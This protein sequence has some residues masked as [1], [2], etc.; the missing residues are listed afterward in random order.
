MIKKLLWVVITLLL[1]GGIVSGEQ[2]I[3]N[4][5]VVY[6]EW[7]SNSW[8][9]GKISSSCPEGYLVL[10]DDGAE[11]CC[12][13]WEIVLDESPEKDEAQVNTAVLAEWSNG[14]FYPGIIAAI[15]EDEYKIQYDDGDISVVKLSQLRL[16]TLPPED[17][18]S[19]VQQNNQTSNSSNTSSQVINTGLKIWRG[20]SIWA[21]ISADGDIWIDG[22]H[23]GEIEPDGD[24]WRG[25]SYVGEIES[26]GDIWIQS[27]KDAEIET[28]GDIWLNS[29]QIAQIEPNGKIWFKS[30]S[31]GEVTPFDGNYEDMKIIAAV[32]I[33]FAPEFGYTD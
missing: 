16:R 28:D 11:K 15:S 23:V 1:L 12:T 21:E 20:G 33:F 10:F 30:S 29:S 17:L 25:S 8:Y 3:P 27:S 9:R 4:E 5:T 18:P 7:S 24:V 13:Q 6:A 32:L 14:R 22:W 26:D 2:T 31:W 19:T